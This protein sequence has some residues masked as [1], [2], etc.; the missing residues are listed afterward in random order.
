MEIHGL[1]INELEDE[2][3]ALKQCVLTCRL[4]RHLAQVLPFKSIVLELLAGTESNPARI[5]C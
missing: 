2:E 3:D 4:Y 1:I 5:L